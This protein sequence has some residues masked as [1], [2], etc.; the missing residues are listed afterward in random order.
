RH[1]QALRFRPLVL[2]VIDGN[3]PAFFQLK[4][5]VHDRQAEINDLNPMRIQ[6][7]V[8][9]GDGADPRAGAAEDL[10]WKEHEFIAEGTRQTAKIRELLRVGQLREASRAVYVEV[11]R[12]VAIVEGIRT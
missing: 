5:M 2:I 3:D 7:L 10:H 11:G 8:F 12:L 4:A 9:D 1:V 6:P